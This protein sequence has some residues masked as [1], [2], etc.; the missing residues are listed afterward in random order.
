VTSC[1]RPEDLYLYLEGE[2][3][4]YDARK[5]E[6]HADDCPACREALAE[7]RLLHEAFTTLAPFE[8]PADF[9]RSVMAGLPEPETRRAGWLAP[10]VAAMASLGIGLLGFYVFTGQRVFGVL[11]SVN[12]FFGQ[13]IAQVAPLAAKT[14][15]IGN[16]VLKVAGDIVDMGFAGLLTFSRLL[17]PE[18]VILV[19]GLG[20]LLSVLAFFGAKRFLQGEGS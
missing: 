9:A 14:L 18:V 13:I 12:R 2:L 4:P 7:R 1:P 8:V 3:G 17:G 11:A 10:L 6:E 16:V 19:L 15:K 20:A 5:I